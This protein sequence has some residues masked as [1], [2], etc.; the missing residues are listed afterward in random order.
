MNKQSGPTYVEACW[1]ASRA[2]RT[3]NKYKD[4]KM[5]TT[6]ALNTFGPLRWV[7]SIKGWMGRRGQR[8]QRG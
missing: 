6:V 3:F 5:A 8:G 2:V 4:M 7:I 1:A